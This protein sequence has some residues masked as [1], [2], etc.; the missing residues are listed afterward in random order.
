M[1]H[2][3]RGVGGVNDTLAGGQVGLNEQPATRT[4]GSYWPYAPPLFDYIRRAMPYHT[5][6]A[7]TD[8]EIY[9]LTAYILHINGLWDAKTPL[10]AAALS[11]VTMPNRARFYSTFELP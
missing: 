9:S 6:G 2:G 4:I 10:D 11:G 7:L 3:E 5:P 8:D 1:C